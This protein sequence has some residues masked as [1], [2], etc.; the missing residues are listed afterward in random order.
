MRGLMGSGC[1]EFRW[2]LYDETINVSWWLETIADCTILCRRIFPPTPGELPS[3][4]EE[5]GPQDEAP[6]ATSTSPLTEEPQSK[7]LKTSSEDIE[8]DW[9]AVDK[10]SE[11][12]SEKNTDISEEGEKVEAPRLADEEGEKV[13]K[14]KETGVVDDLADSGEVLPKSA[15]LKDW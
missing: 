2:P 4:A 9:E 1:R 6:T 11:T 15:L 7:K 10:P 3:A 8:K 5:E 12:A 13:E 14:P